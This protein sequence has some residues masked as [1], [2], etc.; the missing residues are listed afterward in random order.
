MRTVSQDQ[1]EERTRQR[2]P[3][4]G[5]NNDLPIPLSSEKSNPLWKRGAERKHT[6]QIGQCRAS[7]RRRPTHNQLH[8]DRINARQANSYQEPKNGSRQQAA[9]QECKASVKR[10]SQHRAHDKDC[11]RRKSIG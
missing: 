10:C 4:R 5:K 3:G 1:N 6:H 8:A 11:A 9:G 2:K 7:F